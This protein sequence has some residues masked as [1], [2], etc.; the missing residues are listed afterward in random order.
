[1]ARN[2]P[3][4]KFFYPTGAGTE[5]HVAQQFQVEIA[6]KPIHRQFNIH[7]GQCRQ[8]HRR[9]QGRHPLQTPD[10]LGAAAQLGPEAHAAVVH[11]QKSGWQSCPS[12]SIPAQPIE[13]L[14]IEQI[15]R[16]G[17]DPLVLEQLLS[18][19][20]RQDDAHVAECEGER[21]GLER[22]LLRGQSEVRKL[23]AEVGSGT[24]S[25]RAV[26]RLAELQARLAQVE[27]R[28]A[29]L[30]GQMEALQQERLVDVAEGALDRDSYHSGEY[31][32][33]RRSSPIW[34]ACTISWRAHQCSIS[35][36]VLAKGRGS[37][38]G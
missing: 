36:F 14:V 28:L 23:L 35:S 7:V 17:R 38:T 22:D 4:G 25:K 18:T 13:Q 10:A 31:P 33:W 37:T 24:S 6:R 9:V 29:R 21:V 27:Q 20:R 15:Q 30:R 2:L 12:K 16:L 3:V 8:C 26:L 34:P 19:V 32:S 11:A 5:T 1:V